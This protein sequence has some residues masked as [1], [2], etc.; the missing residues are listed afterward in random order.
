MNLSI[1]I[2]LLNEEESLKELYSWII[3]VMQ[4]NNYSYEIIF[5]D[6]GSTDD[7]WNII[8]GFSNENPNVKGI[9]FMKNFGKS[10]ALHA[11]F[12]KAKG[13]VIITM[14]ADLQDSPDEIPELYE[15]ITQQKFDLVSGWKKKRYDSVVAK[16][17][18][19]KLFNWAARKTSGVELND[20]NC[21]LKAYKNVVVKNIE[22]SG[23]MHRY[24][25]VLAKNAGF[26]KIGE[27]VVIHQ[28]RKYGETKFGMER[29]INGFLDLITIWFLSRFGK[30]PMHLFGA[31]GSI[32]FII[33]FLSAGYIGVSKLY[34][35]YNGMK[36]SLVTN[37]PWFFIALTTMILGTQLFL[38]GFLGEIILRTKNNEERYKV[39]RE[40]NF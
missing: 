15:M 26:G 38:A 29:F 21:G 25:P 12:A 3:K 37:N 14:D 32:M 9:R 6:D 18:P 39:S 17:L 27:K 1:L 19:S 22:V 5:V 35:M 2:P 20:F 11:G 23:E 33:G 31:I 8:E 28:A 30:R 24:I 16:N 40:V 34:H 36:Y 10:Q 4:S 13:D 7:S